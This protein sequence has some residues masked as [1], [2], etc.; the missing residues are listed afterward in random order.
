MDKSQLRLTLNNKLKMKEYKISSLGDRLL[1]L[2]NRQFEST[3][4]TNNP[5]INKNILILQK[6]FRFNF[7]PTI[8]KLRSIIQHS[9]GRCGVKESPQWRAGPSG[10]ANEYCNACG[11]SYRKLT[12]ALERL[13]TRR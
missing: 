13:H 10:K 9:C 5:I 11:L 7:N 4:H 12:R 6:G 1:Q 3:S 8:P 2:Y